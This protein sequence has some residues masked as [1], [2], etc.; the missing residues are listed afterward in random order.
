[1]G[2][3]DL[4]ALPKNIKTFQKVC[5]GS[6]AWESAR[7]KTESSHVQ[8]LPSAPNTLN[9]RLFF[10]IGHKLKH[11]VH[12]ARRVMIYERRNVSTHRLCRKSKIMVE[13]NNIA[14]RLEVAGW[15][16]GRGSLGSATCTKKLRM[17]SLIGIRVVGAVNT[18]NS[19]KHFLTYLCRKL[20]KNCKYQRA[21]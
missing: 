7:L 15:V 14:W 6:S 10:N 12:S 1:M 11:Y 20:P 17:K 18:S 8:T 13:A 21:P 19:A 4:I 9:L 16:Q 3:I 5:R 2:R